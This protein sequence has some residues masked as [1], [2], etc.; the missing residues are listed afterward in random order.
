MPDA[1]PEKVKLARLARIIEAQ[2]SIGRRKA[3]ERIGKEVDVLVEGVSKKQPGEL[4][5]RTEWDAMVVFPG[6]ASRIGEFSRVRLRSLSGATFRAE[7]A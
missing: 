4:L 2:R 5:G 6:E 7:R 3:L 1:L